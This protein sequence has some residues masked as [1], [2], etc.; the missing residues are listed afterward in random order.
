MQNMQNMQNTQNMQNM[1]NN[2]MII[3]I[4][5][6]VMIVEKSFLNYQLWNSFK[7]LA[8]SWWGQQNGTRFW[9]ASAI[10][11]SDMHNRF[12]KSSNPGRNR[13]ARTHYGPK[14][15]QTTCQLFQQL[16]GL[17]NWAQL[18]ARKPVWCLRKVEC[19]DCTSYPRLA[20]L[21][22]FLLWIRLL[23][24]LDW[25]FMTWFNSSMGSISC[26]FWILKSNA[27]ERES[28]FSRPKVKGKVVGC[29]NSEQ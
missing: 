11:S 20:F 17:S 10:I 27:C 8:K 24:H 6:C 23:Q 19:Q 9:K 1:Q 29:I 28:F 26:E 21:Y 2:N 18:I 12:D 13:E 15:C 7:T 4:M 14:N 25:L 5:I 22:S 16:V 3:I